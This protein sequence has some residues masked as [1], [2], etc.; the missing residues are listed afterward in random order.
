MLLHIV[1][2]YFPIKKAIAFAGLKIT[3]FVFPETLQL[4]YP[5]TQ[6]HI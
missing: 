2:K 4:F 3:E 5:V 6:E 1:L